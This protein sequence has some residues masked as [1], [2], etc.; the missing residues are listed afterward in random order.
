[1]GLR[2]LG[3]VVLGLAVLTGAGWLGWRAG[4]GT[5]RPVAPE[6]S[7]PVSDYAPEPAPS[8]PSA[9]PVP[10]PPRPRPGLAETPSPAPVAPAPANPSGVGN[11][12]LRQRVGSEI[13]KA[14]ESK[15]PSHKLSEEQYER[16]TDDVMSIREAREKMN[17]LPLTPENAEEHK[18]LREKL[19]KAVADWEDVADISLQDFTAMVQPGVGITN[20]EAEPR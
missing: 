1:M 16:L 9:I 2:H 11:P 13:R 20:E 3:F 8:A 19:G 12:A 4:R 10:P 18:R 15:L 14:F 17:A 6:R 5:D 7:L